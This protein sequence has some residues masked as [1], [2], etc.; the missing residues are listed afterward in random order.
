MKLLSY[1]ETLRSIAINW[2]VTAAI[3]YYQFVISEN[4]LSASVT[5]Q[6]EKAKTISEKSCYTAST[7][8]GYLYVADTINELFTLMSE[9]WEHDKHFVG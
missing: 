5:I 4:Y 2:G 8:T 7:S 1:A 6:Y 3:R 9:E